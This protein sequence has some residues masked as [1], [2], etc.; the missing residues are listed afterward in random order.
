MADQLVAQ[1]DS[2][3]GMVSVTLLPSPIWPNLLRPQAQR[4]PSDLRAT[5]WLKPV[6]MA[7]QSVAP[8]DSWV[9]VNLSTMVPSPS[10]P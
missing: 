7:D 5:V 1:V 4:V 10:W 9:G 6:A 8:V 3:V 2:W